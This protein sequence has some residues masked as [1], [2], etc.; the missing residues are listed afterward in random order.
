MGEENKELK[1]ALF[2]KRKNAFEECGDAG[3]DA[4]SAYA[5]DYKKFL[6]ASK[7]EREAVIAAIALAEKQGFRSYDFGD[8]LE[9]G[10]K[11]YFNNRGKSIYFF[12]IGT[13]PVENGVFISAAHIDS[14]RLDLKQNPLYEDSGMGFFKTHYYGGVKKY[15]WTAIPLALHGVVTKTDGTKVSVVIGEDESDPVLY[16]NDLLPHLAREQ[17]SKTLAQG[18]TGE[19]LNILLGTKPIDNKSGDSAIKLNLMKLLNEKYGFT[20]EDFQSAELCGVPAYKARDI[21]LDRSLIGAYGHDDRVCA[22]AALTA[23]FHTTD[24]KKTV[25]TILADKEEIGSEGTSGMQTMLFLDLLDEIASAFGANIHKLRRNSKCLSADV[26]AAFD[27][28]FAEPYE[29]SNSSYLNGGVCLTKYTGSGGKS[30]TNDASSEYVAYVRNIFDQNG[31][32]WQSGELGKVDAGGGGTVAKYIAKYN[33][34]TVDL[35]V[36]VIS[37]HAPYEVISKLDLYMTYKAF[38]SFNK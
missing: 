5:E 10:G 27:P 35:G 32:V 3:C 36:P 7:T 19:Q 11:Y 8:K 34:E 20:E 17:M 18:I 4:A 25:V 29:R 22:Y 31:V 6:D 38:H 14:P 15:Q 1:E 23:L 16:I 28:N 9:V 24:E 21:G 37:M 30:G 2:Y 13:E 33:I 26:N 12:R